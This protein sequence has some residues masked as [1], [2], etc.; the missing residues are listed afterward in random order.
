MFPSD[1]DF[2]RVIISDVA[3]DWTLAL[4]FKTGHERRIPT[5]APG[6]LRPLIGDV[7][8]AT[9][10]NGIW[11][12]SSC[13]DRNVDSHQRSMADVLDMLDRVGLIRWR[14]DEAADD[15]VLSRHGTAYLG[16]IRLFDG[17]T[18]TGWLP[19]DGSLKTIAHFRRL[20]RVI[21]ISHGGN[22][23][24]T[25]GMPNYP[26]AAGASAPLT[27]PTGWGAYPGWTPYAQRSGNVVTVQGLIR[28]DS[29]AG[30]AIA[31]QHLATIPV[32]FYPTQP[33]MSS[34]HT[35]LNIHTRVDANTNGVI[36]CS[37]PAQ[38]IPVGGWVQLQ[39]T[40]KTL[41]SDVQPGHWLI[42]AD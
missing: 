31:S 4:D 6:G 41:A 25:F 33:S 36:V 14:P 21:G 5:S 38:T 27:Y 32:G 37:G 17:I 30:I 19:C 35:S 28:N 9:K 13:V 16:E 10:A 20:F 7:W 15:D 3:D 23:T 18:P 39:F 29:A 11:E 2:A 12:L 26:T 40:Y 34:V 42:C 24:T 1:R 22:G 8:L